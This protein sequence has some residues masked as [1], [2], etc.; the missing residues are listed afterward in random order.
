MINNQRRLSLRASK[1]RSLTEATSR[2]N[3]FRKKPMTPSV[4]DTLK[5]P[6]EYTK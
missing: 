2:R 4:K 5:E 1:C 6:S 3:R